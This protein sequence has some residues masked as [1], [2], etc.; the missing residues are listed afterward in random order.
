MSSQIVLDIMNISKQYIL[1]SNKFFLKNYKNLIKI[2]A[3]NKITFQIKRSDRV[4]IIGRNGSGKSTLCKI[5]SGITYPTE[6]VIK[7]KGKVSSVLEA[8]T[9]FEPELTGYE[10]IF[11]GGAILGMSRK[12]ITKRVNEIIK[13]SEIGEYINLPLKK[14][15]SGMSI[16][17]AFAVASFLDGE[18][19][20][21]D[22]ILAVADEK[23]R[24]KC[25]NKIIQDCKEHNKTL[26]LVSHD[27]RNITQSC[28]KVL[29]LK[30]GEIA[31]FGN[32]KDTILEYQKEI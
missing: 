32:V 23:F 24:K 11:I 15:S 1:N 5:I 21:L 27:L 20:I 6:G 12:Q 29:Y 10:N 30:N 22:E 18:I 31:G 9:G 17:L 28:N 2:E 8:G 19:I 4:G 16:K 14:Y 13:F 25:I 3:L 7:I 26:L